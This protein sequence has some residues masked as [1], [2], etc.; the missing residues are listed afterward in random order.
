VSG[1]ALRVI[2]EGEGE[3]QDLGARESDSEGAARAGAVAESVRAR[4]VPVHAVLAVPPSMEDVFVDR[5]A[6]SAATAARRP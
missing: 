1:A 4:G 6:Q 3:G 5:V 2:L